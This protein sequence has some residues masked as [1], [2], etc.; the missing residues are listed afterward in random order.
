MVDGFYTIKSILEALYHHYFKDS[1]LFIDVFSPEDR[2]ILKY[3]A[4]REIIGNLIQYNRMDHETVPLKYNIIARD[5]LMIKLKGMSLEDIA[6]DLQK[7]NKIIAKD[8]LIKTLNEIIEDGII[9]GEKRGDSYF[10][11]LNK[12]LNLSE[13]GHKK[14][15]ETK[16]SSIIDWP[17]QFWRSYYNIRELNLT[18]SKDLKHADFLAQ[19][20]SKCA[21][22]GMAPAD[23][24]FKNLVKYYE[25]IKKESI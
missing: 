18:P 7:L 8:I 1:K 6:D 17:T 11:T 9:K 12:E 21:T 20:L 4:A 15:I 13:E 5:Y 25:T 3:L 24:V 19:I 10:Y 22:Q 14:Y 2:I 16:L 23:Y